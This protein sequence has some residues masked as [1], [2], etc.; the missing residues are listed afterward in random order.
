MQPVVRVIVIVR[1]FVLLVCF[2]CLVLVRGDGDGWGGGLRLVGVC[3][4]RGRHGL[5]L[6]LRGGRGGR[7]RRTFCGMIV[8]EGEGAFEWLGVG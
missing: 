1:L 8:E 5:L 6:I 7:G 4:D 2:V 3:G